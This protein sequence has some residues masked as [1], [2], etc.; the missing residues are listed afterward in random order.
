MRR[1][2]EVECPDEPEDLAAALA[3]VRALSRPAGVSERTIVWA[4]MIE[5]VDRLV[6]LHGP[7]NTSDMLERLVEAV[8]EMAAPPAV[9]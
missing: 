8:K 1:G 2:D 9:Q 6:A 7:T 5:A 4:M 3:T